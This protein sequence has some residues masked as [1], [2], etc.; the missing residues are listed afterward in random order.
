VIRTR[1]P[2]IPNTSA[3]VPVYKPS[4]LRYWSFCS[5]DPEGEAL[6]GC[7]QDYKSAIRGHEIT[8]VVSN[9]ANR[10]ANATAANGVTWLPWGDQPAAQI[11]YRN[12]LPAADFPY[13][14]ESITSPTQSVPET[15]GSYYPSAVYC[16]TATFEHGGWKACEKAPSRSAAEPAG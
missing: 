5:Y 11:V 8:F 6:V 9:P 7:V 4:Q 16:A 15:M 14:A 13:A 10:R 12:M 1:A 2:S 3:G